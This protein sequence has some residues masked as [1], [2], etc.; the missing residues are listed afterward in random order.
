ME[1]LMFHCK[2][3]FLLKNKSDVY[4]S[5]LRQLYHGKEAAILY[6]DRAARLGNPKAQAK[7]GSIYE[8]GSFGETMHFAKAF[9]YYNSSAL[10]GNPKAMLGLCRCN[11]KGSH[12]PRDTKEAERL[13]RDVSGWLAA[14]PY[15]EDAAFEWCK[16]AADKGYSEALAMLG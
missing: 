13:E 4:H 14:T 1:V 6:L 8:H 10:Q 7:L 16:R 11:M 2:F 12:G 15:D 5:D 9:D 3:F